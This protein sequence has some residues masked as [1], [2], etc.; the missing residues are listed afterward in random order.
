MDQIRLIAFIVFSMAVLLLWEFW[1]KEHAP[2]PAQQTIANKEASGKAS[3]PPLPQNKALESQGR[4]LVNTDLFT[5]EI[6]EQ[7]GDLRK[8]YFHRYHTRD[9][10]PYVLLS[11]EPQK[12]MIIQTGFVGDETIPNHKT[13]FTAQEK[14]YELAGKDSITFTLEAET[15]AWKAKKIYTFRKD[16]YDIL[17][18]QTLES[19]VSTGKP[20]KGY[21]QILRDE[22][23]AP[24]ASRFIH[25][26]TGGAYYTPESGFEKLPF[27]AFKDGLNQ[28]VQSGWVSMLQHYFVTA[29][30]P[31]T[32]HQLYGRTIDTGLYAVGVLQPLGALGA[33][34]EKTQEIRIFTGPKLHDLL[35]NTAPG[36]EYTVDYGLLTIIAMPLFWVLKFIHGLIPN[37]G[38]AIIILTILIK[39]VFYP[40]SRASYRSMAKMRDLMPR[41]QRLREEYKDDRVKLQEAMMNLYRTEKINPLGGCLPVVVQI[42]VFIALYWM[43]LESA[44][45]R[46]APFMAWIHDLS[47]PDP[48]FILP[49]LMGISML[50]Q[51]KL[52]PTPP[53]PMQAKVMMFMPLIFTVFFAFF[54][55]GLVL[56]WITNNLISILQQWHVLRQSQKS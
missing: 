47:A 14:H 22:H 1:Q 41:M 35:K 7:G 12:I 56:Y 8:L 5:A 34:E 53:D 25:S 3:T 38:V 23:P 17:L 27:K 4:V 19:K 10:Q 42:P 28:E 44:E 6:D 2:P 43:I 31:G 52:N 51:T 40:L 16:S 33:G 46:E 36:L 32:P 26:F 55:S 50:V 45:M 24:D 9:G 20:I 29:L 11:D 37:W 15:P 48:Y 39:M 30:I 54:P 18:R 21:Y 49:V 13:H